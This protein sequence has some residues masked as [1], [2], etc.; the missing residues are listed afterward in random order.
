M[1]AFTGFSP[2]APAFLADLAANNETAWFN[3]RKDDYRDLIQTP[4]RRLFVAVAPAMLEIDPRFDD[5][6]MGGAVSRI[7]RDT[8]FSRDK[9]PYRVKQWMSFRRAGEGWQDRPAFFLAFGPGGYRYGMGFYAASP[10]TMTAIRA[11]IA[12]RPT[13]FAEAMAAAEDA[14][15]VL[16]GEAYRRSR[17]PKGMDGS[18][19]AP[20]Q[21]WFGLKSGHLRRER[22]MEPLFFSPDLAAELTSRLARL[23]P[24]YHLLS[25]QS[26]RTAPP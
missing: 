23:A 26:V 9:S 24:L 25:A 6:P 20:L 18:L 1:T 16:E 7:R 3:A 8:R 12:A 21:P 14:G 4:L 2:Q 11:A 19:P 5:N 17:L 13:P 15:F 22:P 10:A